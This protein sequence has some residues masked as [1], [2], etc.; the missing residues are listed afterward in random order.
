[1]EWNTVE[2]AIKT[3]TGTRTE[4]KGVGKLRWFMSKTLTATSP[5]REGE[6]VGTHYTDLHDFLVEV[7]KMKLV[8]RVPQKTPKKHENKG[9]GG[10]ALEYIFTHH[11]KTFCFQLFH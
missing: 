2:K 10:H 3:E 9:G 6:P 5:P 8:Y 4:Q 11:E 7:N 1:M